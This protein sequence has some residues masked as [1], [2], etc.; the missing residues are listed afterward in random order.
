MEAAVVKK[1]PKLR[2]AAVRDGLNR[3]VL[4]AAMSKNT[5]VAATPLFRLAAISR[6]Q[7]TSVRRT[8]REIKCKPADFGP[9]L[10]L[11]LGVGASKVEFAAGA[12]E[13]SAIAKLLRVPVRLDFG[14]QDTSDY[15]TVAQVGEFVTRLTLS[16]TPKSPFLLQ[17]IKLVA[18]QL[19]QLE[20]SPF[21]LQRFPPLDLEKLVIDR[22]PVDYE[23]L[24]RH[25]I[26]RLDVCTAEAGRFFPD[27]RVLSASIKSLGL[28]QSSRAV[29][30][31]TDSF[32]AFCRRFP[33]LE[34]LHSFGQHLNTDMTELW[35]RCL[36]LRD[37]LNIPGL[38]RLF[39]TGKHVA[40]EFFVKPDDEWMPKLKQV[41]PFDKATFWTDAVS[42]HERVLLVQQFDWPDGAKPTSIRI[43]GD[44]FRQSKKKEQ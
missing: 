14:L 16:F 23:A 17:F 4:T 44:F 32:A 15:L 12:E 13:M 20:C 31:P 10:E 30:P 37:Q 40:V 29:G 26:R 9:S 42:Q 19:K 8:V 24:S 35:A 33:S 39:V 5:K 6:A 7:L 22:T 2:P 36:E 1:K 18:P 3:F 34:E 21:A 43:E 28:T 27:E 11:E 38:K 41:E 25:K